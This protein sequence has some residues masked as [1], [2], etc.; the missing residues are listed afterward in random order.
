MLAADWCFP[1]WKSQ[2]KKADTKYPTS[3]RDWPQ[4]LTLLSENTVI[5]NHSCQER[6]IIQQVFVFKATCVYR[7]CT[8]WQKSDLE[9]QEL[10]NKIIQHIGKFTCTIKCQLANRKNT[11]RPNASYCKT[12]SIIKRCTLTFF[13]GEIVAGCL[14]ML[15]WDATGQGGVGALIEKPYEGGG[16]EEEAPHWM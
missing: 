6:T 4:G 9:G 15:W 2:M 1:K 8:F 5:S 13:S 16:R 7:M 14:Q 3:K 10:W 12:T 11:T